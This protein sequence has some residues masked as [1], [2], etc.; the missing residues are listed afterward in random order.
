MTISIVRDVMTIA[1]LAA[2]VAGAWLIAG[3]GVALVVF[4]VI[5]FV[6]GIAA[7]MREGEA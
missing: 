1:G 6:A 2:I 4:G 3:L 7:T 5:F